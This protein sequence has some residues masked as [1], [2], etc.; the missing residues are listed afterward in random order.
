MCIAGTA[1]ALVALLDDLA[2]MERPFVAPPGSRI[3]ETGG[4][5]GR[6]RV[7][8]R[9]ELYTALARA[10]G[11][12]TEAIVAEYGMTEL[13]S[14]YYDAPESRHAAVRV[15]SAPPWLRTLVIDARGEIVPDGEVGYS[16]I[17]TLAIAR[18]S[19]RSTP[20]TAAIVPPVASSCSVATRTQH[21]ADV[22]SMRKRCYAQART[23]RC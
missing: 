20:K 13:I 15:K 21:R 18:R 17:S 22:R 9:G 3:M 16:G 14:Q 2:E 12:A 4:F 5:K 6:A 7:V 1:F 23:C 10:L 11:I 8:A 19:S